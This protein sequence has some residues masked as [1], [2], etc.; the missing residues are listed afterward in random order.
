MDKEYKYVKIMTLGDEGSGKVKLLQC[1]CRKLAPNEQLQT[2]IFEGHSIRVETAAN[3][4]FV[5][6]LWDVS[7]QE[8]Y[9]SLRC[10]QYPNMDLFLA[11]FSLTDQQS[12]INI[13]EKVK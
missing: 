5:L 2:S 11:C 1:L 12:L 8:N 7:G 10:L 4:S 13:K 3:S 9:S 6:S